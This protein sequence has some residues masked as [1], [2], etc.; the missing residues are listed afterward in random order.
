MIESNTVFYLYPQ[1]L[2]Q[3]HR[4]LTDE[5]DLGRP[6]EWLTARWMAQDGHPLHPAD[7]RRNIAE[8]VRLLSMS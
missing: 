7:L 2:F 5:P 3:A 6:P 4:R 1:H 8:A